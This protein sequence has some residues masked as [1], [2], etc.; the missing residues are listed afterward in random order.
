MLKQH[1][2]LQNTAV[3]VSISSSAY[4]IIITIIVSCVVIERISGLKHA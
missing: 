4:A 3:V 1:L 2:D